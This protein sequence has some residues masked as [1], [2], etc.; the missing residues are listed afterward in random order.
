MIRKFQKSDLKR[1][2]DI[3]LSVNIKAHNFISEQY[4][5]D[6]FEAVKEMIL[7][8]EVY[9]YE[10]ENK[11]VQGFVGLRDDYIAGIFVCIEA[12]SGGIGKRLVNFVKAMKSRLSL[13]VYQKNRRAVKFYQREDFVIQ[14]EDT[15]DNTGEREYFMIWEL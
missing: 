15:D 12:Q 5:R 9:V 7:Q 2:A 11:M 8:A 3:W 14:C 1:V 13:S 6:H 4:W 10:D